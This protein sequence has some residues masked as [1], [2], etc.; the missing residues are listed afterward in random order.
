MFL[1][2][3]FP[4]VGVMLSFQ[5]AFEEP[6]LPPPAFPDHL[7]LRR[8]L[9]LEHKSQALISEA[10]YILARGLPRRMA[11]S[12]VLGAFL[13]DVIGRDEVLTPTS[14]KLRSIHA[15]VAKEVEDAKV[16]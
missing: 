15:R 11:T 12:N 1:A 2:D 7:V 9:Q 10:H 4:V 8:W 3:L 16:G 5:A 13:Q 14:G 6:A